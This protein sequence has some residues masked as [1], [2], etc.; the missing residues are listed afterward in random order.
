MDLSALLQQ[1]GYALIFAGTLVDGETLLM[2]GGY[3]AH[4]GY[5]ELPLVMLTAFVGAICG[6]QLFFYIGRRHARGLLERFPKLRDRVNVALHRVEHHQG[7]VVLTMRFLWGLRMALPLALGM[8]T[9]SARRFFWLNLVS[10]AVWSAAFA[11]IGY[12]ASQILSTLVDD[13]RR[14]EWQVAAGL[15]L[16]ALAALAWHFGRPRVG[17]R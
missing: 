7:K 17:R 8:S 4:H 2:L 9:M 5:L 6:D 12:G 3:F 1:Y 16:V 15:V 10:A 13:L 11:V 14:Y